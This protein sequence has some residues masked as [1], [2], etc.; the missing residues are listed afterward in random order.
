MKTNM[1]ITP[2]VKFVSVLIPAFNEEQHISKC[3]EALIDQSY[4][5]D[6][7]EIIVMDNG[8]HDRTVEISL[9]FGVTVIDAAGLLIGGVRNAGAKIARGSVFAFIDAD[10]V[11]PRNWIENGVNLLCSDE[12][13]GAIGGKCGIR[14]DGT[15]VER[16]WIFEPS[17]TQTKR[18]D[19]LNSGSLFI[20]K[21]SFY[22]VN[23]FDE[24]VRAGEDTDLSRKLVNEGKFLLVTSDIGVIH[25]G[26]P[27]T[28]RDF[29]NRQIWQSSDYLRT[30][31]GKLDPVLLI[32]HGFL[33]SIAGCLVSALRDSVT[34]FTV[35]FLISAFLAIFLA[36]FRY[37]KQRAEFNLVLFLKV[38][39]LNYFYLLARSIGLIISYK[40]LFASLYK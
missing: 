9:R 35:F 19:I 1:K 38:I 18:T 33:V 21:K 15:W 23:G 10:C 36:S 7:Y 17:L 31:K 20:T 24:T 3:L 37:R 29:V 12:N 34:A 32:T 4:P 26:Y 6:R 8:S 27:R 11:P 40:R 13:I 28:L 22:C 16:A 25:L 39:Y 2:K 30:Q 14:N 5:K